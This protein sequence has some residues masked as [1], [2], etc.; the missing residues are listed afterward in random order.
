MIRLAALALVAVLGSAEDWR[1]VEFTLAHFDTLT[2]VVGEKMLDPPEPGSEREQRAWRRAAEMALWSLEPSAELLPEAY[3]DHLLAQAPPWRPL[4][5]PEPLPCPGVKA[6]LLTRESVSQRDPAALQRAWQGWLAQQRFDRRTL[7]CCITWVEAALPRGDQRRPGLWMAWVNAASGWLKALD[8]HADV[9]AAR[10]WEAESEAEHVAARADPGL[11]LARC[12]EPQPSTPW[13]CC[14]VDVRRDSAA[15]RADVRVGD[16]VG[17]LAH[18]GDLCAAPQLLGGE[19]DEPLI[20]PL[21]SRRSAKTRTLTLLRDRA[22]TRDV[23]AYALPGGAVHLQVRDFV[24]GTAER[25]M[26]AAA[27][28]P[29]PRSRGAA[30]A[31][32]ILDLRGN[33]GGILDESVAL[34]DWLLQRGAIVQTRWRERTDLRQAVEGP[35]ELR[36]PLVVLL[37]RRCGSACEVLAGAVQDHRRGPLLGARSFGKASMQKVQKTSQMAD[38]Y[39]KYTIGRYLTPA[40][41]DIDGR[42]L[43]PDV[44]LPQDP[45]TAFAVADDS[46]WRPAQRCVQ[47]S[48]AA[49]RRLAAEVAPRQRPDP[50]LA[51]AA[52]WLAC[53]AKR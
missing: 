31:G 23:E 13:D 30:A 44:A 47:A 42:G 45:T 10:F 4:Q 2:R 36:A 39:V 40:G 7:L 35:R 29:K 50:W 33:R 11:S 43:Q 16:R 6:L 21:W 12:R 22:V 26:Q 8:S 19:P 27:G 51:M 3:V 38:F 34:A 37:D 1:G 14:V 17:P 48:G 15:W 32:L 24:R 46:P 9:I 28:L 25:A 41:R 52:D 49:P 53:L 20:L 18:G 5:P